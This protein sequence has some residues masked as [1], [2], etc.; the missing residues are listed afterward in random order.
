VGARAVKHFRAGLAAHRRK[1]TG[2]A[3]RTF[4]A[5]RVVW[6]GGL[7][8]DLVGT[9]RSGCGRAPRVGAP[10][11]GNRSTG[12]AS[13]GPR[14]APACPARARP[15]RRAGGGMWADKPLFV[16]VQTMF[17]RLFGRGRTSRPRQCARPAPSAGKLRGREWRVE[18]LETRLTPSWIQQPGVLHVEPGRQCRPRAPG[19]GHQRRGRDGDDRGPGTRSHQLP[20]G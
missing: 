7:S 11:P 10:R 1:A 4:F 17:A 16:E 18:E 5:T 9:A 19:R 13:G 2:R 14:L 3:S 6:R 15:R 8:S 20:A 12:G